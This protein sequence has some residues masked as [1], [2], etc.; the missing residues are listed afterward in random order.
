VRSPFK[1]LRSMKLAVALIAYLIVTGILASL[2]SQGREA[3]YYYSTLPPLLAGLVVKTGF[4]NF[5]GS[6]LFLI[7]ALLFFANLSACAADRLVREFKKDRAVRRH[8][9]DILHL[10]LILLILSAVFAQAA[11]LSRP[12]SQGFVRLGKGEAV[13]LPDGRLLSVLALRADRYDDGRPKDWVSTVEVRKGG[14]ILVP[15][16]DIRVNHPLRLG[17][18][19]I[20]QSSYGS[21]RVIVLNSPSGE[22]RSLSAGESIETDSKRIV[23]MSVDT[24]TGTAVAR[25]EPNSVAADAAEATEIRLLRL[26]KGSMIGPFTFAGTEELALSGLMASY[27]P[28]YPA[29]LAALIIAA[30][31]IFITFAQK[32]GEQKA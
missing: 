24:G 3:S 7:P 31:G 18:L 17:S 25:E 27:D 32:L 2:L 12:D 10:G 14:K 1:A 30:L 9:P 26:G 23:L 4:S 20:F 21:E 16:Y 8:G 29:I 22:R 28:A 6:L 5:Y 11:K 19:S 13:E 15:S